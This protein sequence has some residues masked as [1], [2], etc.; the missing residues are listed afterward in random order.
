[1]HS[2]SPSQQSTSFPRKSSP[3]PRVHHVS[4]SNPLD[5]L[6]FPNCLL[7]ACMECVSFRAPATGAHSTGAGWWLDGREGEVML[8]LNFPPRKGR[9]CWLPLIYLPDLK[10]LRSWMLWFG[11]H[12]IW[13]NLW[14]PVEGDVL[15]H[16][17]PTA[18]LPV[19]CFSQHSFQVM[20]RNSTLLRAQNQPMEAEKQIAALQ[21]PILNLSCSHNTQ[22]FLTEELVPLQNLPV[23]R[24]PWL[25]THTLDFS[26]CNPPPM[27]HTIFQKW[28]NYEEEK[29]KVRRKM[30][31]RVC[32]TWN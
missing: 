5:G 4:C 7:E 19:H 13:S 32:N 30:K 26:L 15:C 10:S 9:L 6:W 22:N 24:Q 25:Q 2:T 20:Q 1:M 8:V 17:G 16:L 29:I 27:I 14:S 31:P 11:G 21:G 3:L 12:R 28:E 23:H 18:P